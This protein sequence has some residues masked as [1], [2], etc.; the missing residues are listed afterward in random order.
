MLWN[1]SNSLTIKKPFDNRYQ[2]TIT[3]TAKMWNI[4]DM[5]CIYISS[6]TEHYHLIFMATIGWWW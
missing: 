4:K 3:T 1:R 2:G 5:E 6:I